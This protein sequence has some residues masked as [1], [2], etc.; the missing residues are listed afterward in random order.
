MGAT[1]SHKL[2]AHWYAT[3]ACTTRKR[4]LR[5]DAGHRSSVLW[6][7]SECWTGIFPTNWGCRR[8]RAR[9]ARISQSSRHTSPYWTR[10]HNSNGATVLLKDERQL[11]LLGAAVYRLV[12]MLLC[13]TG[14]PTFL[15]TPL[16]KAP[17]ISDSDADTVVTSSVE[18]WEADIHGFSRTCWST[19]IFKALLLNVGERKF[20]GLVLSKT[21]VPKRKSFLE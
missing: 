20:S 7:R 18:L 4:R 3:F 14:K 1:S 6:F 16:P 11:H 12:K 21:G 17:R 8:R 15:N 10:L 2:L 19:F 9:A 5:D 13:G